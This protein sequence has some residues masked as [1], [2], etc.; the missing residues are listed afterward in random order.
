M[1]ERPHRDM[2][3][4]SG[5]PG[6]RGGRGA[7]LTNRLVRMDGTLVER[8]RG[9]RREPE[10]A[11]L[12]GFHALKH[13]LRFGAEVME[14]VSP[15]PAGLVRLARSLAP[16]VAAAVEAAVRPVPADLFAALAPTPPPTG[17]LAIARRPPVDVAAAL[18]APGAAPAVLLE[19]PRRM[20]NLGAAIRAAA[21]ADAAAVLAIGPH[22]PWHPAAIRGAA[23]LQFALPVAR[24]DAPPDT[25]RPLV[26]LVP[27]CTPL[28]P[29]VAPAR[30]LLAFGTE[31]DGV[32]AELR[33]RA[34]LACG[35]PMRPGVSS[36]NLAT[37]VAVALW[38][39]RPPR[40]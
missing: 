38:T 30:A 35:I 4:G 12:E 37:A 19:R 7:G 27:G 17:V 13:A 6:K 20:G 32:S 36:L 3:G 23:G 16:D 8:W 26:V 14:V 9:A 10:W 33:A 28:A 2:L 5:V 22:D 29:G 31:R 15:D 39:V 34:D 1:V 11:V 25:D 18:A 21:A 40:P 24:L